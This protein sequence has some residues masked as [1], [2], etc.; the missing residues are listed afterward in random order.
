MR[1]PSKPS[2][3]Q[4]YTEPNLPTAHPPPLMFI[5]PPMRTPA[6][7]FMIHSWIPD[8]SSEN[9]PS[10]AKFMLKNPTT[11]KLTLN[12]ITYSDYMYKMVQLIF[13]TAKRK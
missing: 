5:T 3:T 9:S 8:L 10:F 6:N 7:T 2:D 12:R 1:P 13:K 4:D 11:G